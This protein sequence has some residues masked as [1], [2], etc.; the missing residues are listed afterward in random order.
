M[1]ACGYEPPWTGIIEAQ[2]D[3]LEI[4]ALITPPELLHLTL[5]FL[6]FSLSSS[7]MALQSELALD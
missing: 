6:V 2:P 3:S 7:H 4:H 1:A 5:C